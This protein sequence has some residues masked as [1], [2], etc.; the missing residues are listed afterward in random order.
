MKRRIAVTA[1]LALITSV[2]TYSTAVAT[3]F[4]RFRCPNGHIISVNQKISEVA[5]K[6]DPPTLVTKRTETRGP[7]DD[8]ITVEV[9]EWVYNQGPSLFIYFLTFRNGRLTR[10]ETGE[11]GN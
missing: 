10:I 5:I 9:E 1:S 4:D 8:L 6:C 2:V 7:Y 3:T 11:Y